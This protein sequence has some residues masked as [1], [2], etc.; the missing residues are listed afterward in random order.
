MCGC[1]HWNGALDMTEKKLLGSLKNLKFK[2]ENIK[3][4]N[5]LCLYLVLI[6]VSNILLSTN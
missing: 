3:K 1:S 5:N 6:L 4:K 2:I